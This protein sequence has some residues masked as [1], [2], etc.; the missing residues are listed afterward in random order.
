MKKFML[1]PLVLALFAALAPSARALDLSVVGALGMSTFTSDDTTETFSRN[2]SW[3]FGALLDTPFIPMLFDLEVG[4]LYL[5]RSVQQTAVGQAPVNFTLNYLQVP[6]LL[7]LV[8]FPMISVGAGLYWNDALGNGTANGVSETT[9]QINGTDFGWV[10]SIAFRY[11][12]LPAIKLLVDGRYLG[13]FTN[14]ALQ[15]GATAHFNDFQ[16][17]AGLS[18]G[19]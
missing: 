4:A 1:I 5:P 15:A 11:P 7:R 3:G 9:A 17:L 12:L 6:V 13:G 16:L 10:G 8:A 19:L 14:Q 18:L 2:S